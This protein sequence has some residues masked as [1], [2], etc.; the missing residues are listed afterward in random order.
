MPPPDN[1]GTVANPETREGRIRRLA[2]R[3][4]R[5]SSIELV[6]VSSAWLLAA[7]AEKGESPE[8]TYFKL[9]NHN[10]GRLA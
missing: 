2:G 7:L 4:H 6:K 1:L 8:D 10:G 5:V 9:D 3:G